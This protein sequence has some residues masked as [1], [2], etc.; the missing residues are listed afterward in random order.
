MLIEILTQYLSGLAISLTLGAHILA[1]VLVTSQ[2][3]TEEEL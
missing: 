2:T 3:S 1:F